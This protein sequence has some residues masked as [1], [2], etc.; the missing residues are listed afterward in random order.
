LVEAFKPKDIFPCTV[1]PSTWSEEVSIRNLFGH[2]CSG[3]LF[4]HDELMRGNAQDDDQR[5]RKRPRS[6][7]SLVE[8]LTQESIFGTSWVQ[9]NERPSTPDEIHFTTTIES[10][11]RLGRQHDHIIQ[12]GSPEHTPATSQSTR[13]RGGGEEEGREEEGG[14]EE[15]GE[16]EEVEDATTSASPKSKIHAIKL[17][18]KQYQEDHEVQFHLSS[19]SASDSDSNAAASPSLRNHHY[20]RQD[21]QQQRATRHYHTILSAN[22]SR[23]HKND[24]GGDDTESIISLSPSAFDSQQTEHIRNSLNNNNGDDGDDNVT[25]AIPSGQPAQSSMRSVEKSPSSPQ[26][27]SRIAAYRA[28]RSGRFEAW[29]SFFAPVTAGNNHTE[30]EIEL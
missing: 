10:T 20:H 18:L 14:E 28:A 9:E 19:S 22:P 3:T 11:K 16:E 21:H 23:P 7:A 15:E 30:E 8:L 12:I 13:R 29:S 5:P 17:A 1:D 26:R 6:D 27:Y 4:V 24:S 2:L 25:N